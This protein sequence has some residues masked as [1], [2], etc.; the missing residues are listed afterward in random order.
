MRTVLSGIIVTLFFLNGFT[1]AQDKNDVSA[2]G[3]QT[4]KKEIVVTDKDTTEH[5]DTNNMKQQSVKPINRNYLPS[6]SVH[7]AR[8]TNNTVIVDKANRKVQKKRYNP[9]YPNR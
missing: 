3:K 7:R 8:R 2:R 1:F 4:A 9:K 5:T 6:R